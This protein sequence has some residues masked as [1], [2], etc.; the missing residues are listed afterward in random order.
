MQT[1]TATHMTVRNLTGR[2]EVIINCMD[3]T[4]SSP[5]MFDDLHSR[6]IN[7]YGTVRQNLKE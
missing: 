2:V 4:F 3:S 7:C 1:M 6:G 5:N